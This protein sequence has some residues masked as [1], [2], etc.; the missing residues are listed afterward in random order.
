L[1]EAHV[2]EKI[3]TLAGSY[4]V[5]YLDGK[6]ERLK[7]S[8]LWTL[9]NV[10]G[11]CDK[12]G[13]V[14]LQMQI[15][16]KLWRLYIE[17]NGCQEDAAIC[18]SLVATRC[19]QHVS[20]EDRRYI[21]QNLPEKLHGQPASEYFMY[22]VHQLEIVTQE[23][24]LDAQQAECLVRFFEATLAS[25]AD[26]LCLIYGV[27]VMTNLVALGDTSLIFALADPQN[28]VQTLNQLFALRDPDLNLDAMRLLKNCLH[29]KVADSNLVLN[30][31]QIYA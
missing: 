19:P 16:P 29:L 7:R 31:L 10:L 15:V 22:I 2:S 28:L 9:A 12:A 23:H 1:G 27:R 14:L 4:M 6:A 21:G 11:T 30:S 17:P 18:L 25:P 24:K 3:V 26:R 13:S 8:C 20:D 5:T